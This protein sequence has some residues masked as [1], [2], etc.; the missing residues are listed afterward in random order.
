MA[1]DDVIPEEPA[2]AGVAEEEPELEEVEPVNLLANDARSRLR[3]DGFSDEEIGR[4]AEAFVEE[5][6]QS[7]TVDELVAWIATRERDGS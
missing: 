6:G 5:V 3:S 4:W 2:D 7:G 1:D